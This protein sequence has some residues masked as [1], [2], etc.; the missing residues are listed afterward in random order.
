MQHGWTG[1]VQSHLPAT[2]W[3]HPALADISPTPARRTNSRRIGN[4]SP[5]E[6]PDRRAHPCPGRGRSATG[7][8]PACLRGRAYCCNPSSRR[9]RYLH[10]FPQVGRHQDSAAKTDFEQ[11]PAT[12]Q[13]D[14]SFHPRQRASSHAFGGPG[15]TLFEHRHLPVATMAARGTTMSL[16]LDLPP[17]VETGARGGGGSRRAA[18]SRVRGAPTYR[19]NSTDF[20]ATHRCRSA[21]LLA[22]RRSHRHVRR[23][24]GRSGA[25]TRLT[26][27]STAEGPGLTDGSI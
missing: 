17:E 14:M 11:Q 25:C 16:V 27:T 4:P 20:R 21:G 12:F 19:W 1:G 24:H 23:Y 18:A 5:S 9:H 6:R 26:G 15:E 8:D 7:D 2:W 22:S 3:Q 10:Q 13:R